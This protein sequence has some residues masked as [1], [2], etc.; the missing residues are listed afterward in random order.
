MN[1]KRLIDEIGLLREQ[2][3]KSINW[4]ESI[5]PATNQGEGDK[6]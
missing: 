6:K 5:Q 2:N 1:K 3:N 4:C